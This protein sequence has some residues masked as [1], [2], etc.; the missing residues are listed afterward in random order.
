MNLFLALA[1]SAFAQSPIDT[2]KSGKSLAINNAMISKEVLVDRVWRQAGPAVIEQVINE[3]LIRQAAQA[4]KI[5]LDTKKASQRL[6]RL[7]NQALANGNSAELLR[8]QVGN[9]VLAEQVILKVKSINVTETEIKAAFEANKD[10]LG[11]PEQVRLRHIQVADEKEA[12]EIAAA[13]RD[14]ANF[15]HLAKSKSLDKSSKDKGGDLGYFT[16]GV[17]FIPEVENIAFALKPKE[18]SDPVKS[19]W[20]FH[21]L[22]VTE[23]LSAKGA[24]LNKE[25]RDFLKEQMIQQKIDQALPGYL[26]ELRSKAVIQSTL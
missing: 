14:G 15:A 11:T 2:Q 26:Q 25:T 10:R 5:N 24:A 23:R 7:R 6:E 12:K 21:I 13:L 9:R 17:F 1:V 19:P 4:L 20:G 22:Q 18:I 8:D 3:T 16:R